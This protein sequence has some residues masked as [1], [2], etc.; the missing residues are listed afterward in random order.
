MI[1]VATALDAESIAGIYNHYVTNTAISF[2]E[3]EVTGEEI[4]KRI[5]AIGSAYP[6]LVFERHGEVLGYAYGGRFAARSAYRFTAEG[7]VYVAHYARQG[8]IGTKLYRKLIDG[9]RAQRLHSVLGII[10]LPNDA[11]VRLHEKCGFRKVGEFKDVGWKFDQWIDV[12]YWQLL[13]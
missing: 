2:E 6:W 5:S 12:G 8:G 10:A 13:L 9:L 3:A 7:T 4:A 11:S 1:R